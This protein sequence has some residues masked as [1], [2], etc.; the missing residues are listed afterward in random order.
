MAG[1]PGKDL[2]TGDISQ[3][4]RAPAQKAAARKP[5]T[6]RESLH[7]ASPKNGIPPKRVTVTSGTGT[8]PTTPNASRS[9][10]SSSSRHTPKGSLSKPPARPLSKGDGGRLQTSVSSSAAA[11][12]AGKARSSVSSA[13]GPTTENLGFPNGKGEDMKNEIPSSIERTGSTSPAKPILRSLSN[14]SSH[15]SSKTNGKRSHST[16]VQ[17]S[18]LQTTHGLDEAQTQSGKD[19]SRTERSGPNATQAKAIQNRSVTKRPSISSI[20]SKAQTVTSEPAGAPLARNVPSP[21]KMRPGLGTRKSTMSV[22][23]EQRLREMSL[24]H[25]MLHAAMVEDGD[26]DDEVKEQYGKQ[27]DET[28]AAL[29]ARLKEAKHNEGLPDSEAEPD[30]EPVTAEDQKHLTDVDGGAVN[31]TYDNQTRPEPSEKGL[32]DHH[33]LEL[34]E[35][36]ETLLEQLEGVDVSALDEVAHPELRVTKLEL[37]KARSDYETLYLSKNH[38]TASLKE[39]IE[40]LTSSL[41]S[42]QESHQ[43]IEREVGRLSRVNDDLQN[44]ARDDESR[45]DRETRQYEV[46]LQEVRE[47]QFQLVKNKDK[48]IFASQQ[49]ARVLQ[50]QLYELQESQERTEKNARTAIS[51]LNE[52][53]QALQESSTHEL[54]QHREVKEALHGRLE[55]YEHAK[56]EYLEEH[57]RVVAALRHELFE[58]QAE[59]DRELKHLQE[60]IEAL[61]DRI[62]NLHETKERELEAVKQAIAKE[63]EEAVANLQLELRKATAQKHEGAQQQYGS[64]GS[65]DSSTETLHKTYQSQL[66]QLRSTLAS[67]HASNAELRHDVDEQKQCHKEALSDLNSA[68]AHS[69]AERDNLR[70]ET[71]TLRQQC[72]AAEKVAAEP[73]LESS[74]HASNN[75]SD[76][77]ASLQQELTTLNDKLISL[78]EKNTGA[79]QEL[80]ASRKLLDDLREENQQLSAGHKSEHE[81]L[82]ELRA[83]LEYRA[84]KAQ[85]ECDDLAVERITSVSQVESLHAELAEAK[86]RC[87][88]IDQE[89]ATLRTDVQAANQAKEELAGTL[90]NAKESYKMQVRELESAL[91]VTTAELVELRTDRPNSSSYSGSP[92]PRSGLRSSRWGRK[93]GN[94]SDEGD[95]AFVGEDM[96]SH[97]QGQPQ[98]FSKSNHPLNFRTS[99]LKYFYFQMAGMREHLRQMD[100][101]NE[102]MI[103]EQERFLG[104]INRVAASSPKAIPAIPYR[105]VTPPRH[106]VNQHT[107]YSTSDE[108]GDE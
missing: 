35:K 39:T 71:E 31:P 47:R 56:V 83:E 85:E 44:R 10:V 75:M 53:I 3:S 93:N 61:Q 2:P 67:V 25:Q 57:A 27:M 6:A 43:S 16:L 70:A 17:S 14:R 66:D 107:Q 21:K 80:V 81:K 30:T 96:S 18:K 26:Q 94:G 13:D 12:V 97:I 5:E 73:R 65:E 9:T 24:V 19:T 42:I 46:T 88:G 41:R 50:N 106:D 4:G 68:L 63:H 60:A 49:S 95:D 78:S 33:A 11:V 34:R 52:R 103:K 37:L 40:C 87:D 101:M 38:E 62:S 64:E 108:A 7:K 58:A 76:N 20:S 54:S 59:K 99:I 69:V 84:F 82:R 55:Q 36:E 105:Y 32:G 72:T 86:S 74:E 100:E 91:K 77:V 92:I 48:D 51:S 8:N 102:D 15:A 29:K 1:S 23:I 79:E 90:Q 89:L 28:L 45:M 104:M 22:T 98:F